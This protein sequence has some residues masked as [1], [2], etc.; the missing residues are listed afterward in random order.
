MENGEKAAGFRETSVAVDVGN[1]AIVSCNVTNSL[2]HDSIIAPSLIRSSYQIKRANC[3]LMDKGYDSEKI[4]TLIHDELGAE[5]IIPVRLWGNSIPNG[6]YRRQMFSDFPKQKY[7][8]RNLVETTFSVMKRMIGGKISSKNPVS[9]K[10]KL[11]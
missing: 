5:S 2:H 11:N 9:K 1:Q 4:H 10:G 8:M 6:K 7:Q 3:Y